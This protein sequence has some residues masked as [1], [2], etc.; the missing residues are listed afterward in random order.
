M[1]HAALLFPLAL[2]S[3][4]A[5]GDLTRE[6]QRPQSSATP[7]A[8]LFPETQEFRDAVAIDYI[9][10]VNAHSYVF[11]EPNAGL[12]RSVLS[13]A[14]ANSGLAASTPTRARYALAVEVLHADGPNIGGTA[15]SSL[16]VRYVLRERATGQVVFAQDFSSDA[17]V[18]FLGFHEDDAWRASQRSWA[19]TRR[20][21]LLGLAPAVADLLYDVDLTIDGEGNQWTSSGW[22]PF[23][24]DEWTHEDWNDFWQ[25]YKEALII[26]SLIGPVTVG[27]EVIN[28]WN[29]LPWADD[30]AA[31]HARHSDPRGQRIGSERAAYANYRVVAGNVTAFLLAFSGQQG[32]EPMPIL[33]CHGSPRIEGFKRE[34]LSRGVMFRSDDCSIPR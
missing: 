34:L 7:A 32:V 19:A 11:A 31:R 16:Q 10:G 24:Y 28:P 21:A 1:R 23:D 3:A 8:I 15:S 17:S 20:V 13:R 2:V 22:D 26:T 29:F 9:S 18:R 6:I 12:I 5:S 14:L 27:A 4:C 30:E 33:P 25:V